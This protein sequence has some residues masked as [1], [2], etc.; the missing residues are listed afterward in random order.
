MKKVLL[1]CMVLSMGVLAASGDTNPGA[2]N[3]AAVPVEITAEVVAAPD[4]LVITDEAG[5]VLTEGLVLEHGRRSQGDTHTVS[6][7]FKVKRLTNG[8]A[9]E[10]GNASG[11]NLTVTLEDT[12][13]NEI[14]QVNLGLLGG[15]IDDKLV[16]T[17]ALA[18]GGDLSGKHGY[19]VNIGTTAK[20]HIGE[21]SS[22]INVSATQKEGK[23]TSKYDPA[24]N[25]KTATLKVV[26]GA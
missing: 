3:G 7:V 18:N 11:S 20:E 6:K 25:E 5:N 15:G 10:V 17:V 13:N 14:N 26:L 21:I 2:A 24:G 23:Y 16:S 12:D 9:A 1:G 8:T 4:S 22:T 19:T